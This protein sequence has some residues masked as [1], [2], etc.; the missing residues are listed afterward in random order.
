[1]T[2][3]R[4]FVRN[5]S[6]GALGAL[7]L[8]AQVPFTTEP[9]KVRVGIVGGRF[10]AS[11]QFHEHPDCIVEAVS[12]LRADRRAVLQRTY[13]CAKAY[14]SLEELIKDPKVEAVFLATPAPDHVRHTLLCLAAGKHVLS[15]VPAAMTLDECAQLVG[16]VKR[17]GL[18]YMMGETSCWQQLTISAR[19]FYQEGAFGRLFHVES[20]YHHPG[21]ESLY[22]ENGQ[23]TWRHGLPPMHYPT[24][25]TAH[26]L[27]ITGE[28]LVEVSCHGWG[29]DDP[30]LKDN[31]YKNPFWNE[32][33]LFRT[34][35]GN[36]M[37][38]AVWWRG[39][40]KGG[41]R[42]RYYG[43]RLSFYHADPAGLGG[44]VVVRAKPTTEKDSGGFSRSAQVVER[45]AAPAWWKT[46]LLPEPLRHDSGHEGSHCFIT[47]E[48]VDSL[49]K[50]RKPLVDVYAAVAFTA[51]GMIAHQSAL[52][53][54]ATLKVP[55]F[56]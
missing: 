6:L 52:Q 38:V 16:A 32:T 36:S 42:A 9:R 54:G 3:R 5:L 12:D 1:M 26:L 51:P 22:F 2:T 29:D 56:D 46:D 24:H 15:A 19:K 17:S 34:D 53:G 25:C 20:E 33:A 30:I 18:T 55:S 39:A 7:T 45:Y 21:L 43:D 28:R 44:P 10:G 31:A 40:Q 50:G 35:R 23:R 4:H 11:F 47:H 37:R 13:R 48:F 27:G 41:E 14:P 8:S 49:V